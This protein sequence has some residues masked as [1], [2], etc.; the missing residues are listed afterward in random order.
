MIIDEKYIEVAICLV[1]LLFSFV[2]HEYA[3]GWMANKLGD[4]T[5]KMMGRLTL[6]PI[7][8]IDL[9]GTILLPI[10]LFILH[11]MGSPV[12]PLILAKPVPVNFSR[13]KNPKRGII[14]VGMA[15]PLINIF[16]AILV[17]LFLRFDLGFLPERILEYMVVINLLLAIFNMIPIP[18]L[19]G[20]R[21][22]M[23]LLPNRLA[24][25]YSRLEPIGILIVFALLPLGLYSK[26]V[27]PIMT[28][29]AQFL[30]VKV[31]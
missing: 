18:P 14:Y 7:K 4:P 21:L 3:H 9:F 23:G 8:H 1:V 15:G 2:I 26:V 11:L 19:D 25:L 5:A 20:S 27:L 13:L 22:V 6:N 29:C 31:L 24:N 30:G 10:F 12:M 16:T 28:V 17:S